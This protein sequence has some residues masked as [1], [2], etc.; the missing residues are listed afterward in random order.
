M[1]C[2]ALIPLKTLGLGKTRLSPGLSSGHRKQLVETM[3]GAVIKALIES[4]QVD[5]IAIVG[6]DPLHCPAS[7][8][9][10]ADPGQ[11]LNAALT[12]GSHQLR[13][14]GADELL[15]IHADLPLVTGRDVDAFISA[16]RQ[17]GIALAG[18]RHGS[19]TN[20]LFLEASSSF[21]FCFGEN[22]LIQ[23]LQQADI[24]GLS[25]ALSQSPGLMI[26]IDTPQ[27]LSLLL[28]ANNHTS[29]PP[30]M[31]MLSHA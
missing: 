3:L 19:G 30:L 25:P 7:V 11:G 16:G 8:L 24:C 4:T 31:R 20:A 14:F 6:M 27:D 10:L 5:Q 9:H 17:C 1:T 22:S 18:D 12:F 2:A 29:K 26:D 23:H 28:G 15:I 13:Q 21:R